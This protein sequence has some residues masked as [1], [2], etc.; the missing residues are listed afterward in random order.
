MDREPQT[1]I[2]LGQISSFTFLTQRTSSSALTR[3]PQP[4]NGQYA[5]KML[6]DRLQRDSAKDT[7]D[8]GRFRRKP[9]RTE[10]NVQ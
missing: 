10:M 8:L 2:P 5:L 3:Q 9:K 6:R 4:M 1:S 7:N